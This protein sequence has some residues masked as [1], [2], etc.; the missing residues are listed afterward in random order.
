M[1]K[2]TQIEETSDL[3]VTSCHIHIYWAKDSYGR[4][5]AVPRRSHHR[6][7]DRRPSQELTG[8]SDFHIEEEDMV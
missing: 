5:L 7:S 4:R 6:R 2:I 3:D 1:K 8:F